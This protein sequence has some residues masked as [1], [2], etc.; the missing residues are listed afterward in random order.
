[1]ISTAQESHKARRGGRD[2]GHRRPP[3]ACGRRSGGPAYGECHRY[4]APRRLF[5]GQRRRFRSTFEQQASSTLSK[6]YA[7]VDV[8]GATTSTYV[9]ASLNGK[10][11]PGACSAVGTL[12]VTC[13]FKSVRPA[14]TVTIDVGVTPAAFDVDHP[15]TAKSTWGTTGFGSGSGDNS[16]GDTWNGTGATASF[17]G[18]G[19]YAGGF[20]EQTIANFQVVDKNVNTQAARLADLPVGVAASVDDSPSNNFPCTSNSVVDCSKLSGYWVK[21]DVGGGA[22]FGSAFQVQIKYYSGTPSFFVHVYTD[23]SGATQQETILACG[24]KGINPPC[25]TWSNQTNTATIYT[26]HNGGVRRN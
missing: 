4:R 19:D 15:V 16:H 6:L 23:A 18:S 10:V 21:V 22:T 5:G 17:N 24:K 25:F 13:L 8:T 7:E 26:F 20:N 1:M 2:R 3:A 11:V 9:S 14:S 12:P